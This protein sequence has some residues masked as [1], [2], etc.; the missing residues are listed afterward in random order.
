VKKKISL[1]GG[2]KTVYESINTKL[3]LM[4]S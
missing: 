3:T 2:K 4:Y 1:D